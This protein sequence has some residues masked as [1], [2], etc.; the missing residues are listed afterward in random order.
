MTFLICINMIFLYHTSPSVEKVF[1]LHIY[2]SSF[3]ISIFIGY[4]SYDGLSRLG[5]ISI[6]GVT[7]CIFVLFL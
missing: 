4:N 1:K 7:C 2:V 6:P 3:I 5:L